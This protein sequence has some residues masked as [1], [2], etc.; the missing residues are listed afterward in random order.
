M[1]RVAETPIY[2]DSPDLFAALADLLPR[3]IGGDEF[4]TR[5]LHEAL[6]TWLKGRVMRVTRALGLPDDD[7]D[8]VLTH[9]CGAVLDHMMALFDLS[10]PTL[11]GLSAWVYTVASN[12]AL[13]IL[14]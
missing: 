12:R 7:Y 2:S 8:I 3:H 11:D 14:E 9:T 5:R 4:A 10:D 6:M 1:T 13:T